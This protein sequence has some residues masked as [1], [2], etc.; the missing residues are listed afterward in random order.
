MRITNHLSLYF[1]FGSTFWISQPWKRHIP[2]ILHIY[3]YL[4]K[5]HSSTQTNH[6]RSSG[7]FLHSIIKSDISCQ[8]SKL[9]IE[10]SK[11]SVI[12]SR[13]IDF[14]HYIRLYTYEVMMGCFSWKFYSSYFYKHS[15]KGWY[16]VCC[17]F[18]IYHCLKQYSGGG[19]KSPASNIK[20]MLID[21]SYCIYISIDLKKEPHCPPLKSGAKPKI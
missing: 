7:P 12:L 13:L 1:W 21:N 6:T 15:I 8:H 5:N 10:S 19:F 14:I 11:R 18:N 2:P 20:L 16:R 3:F 17:D 4:I 9:E